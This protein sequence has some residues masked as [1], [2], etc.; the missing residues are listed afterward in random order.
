MLLNLVSNSLKFTSEG[1][2]YVKSK[3]FPDKSLEFEVEDSGCGISENDQ[4]GLFS[5]FGMG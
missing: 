5:L 1:F 4:K 2:V 3:I